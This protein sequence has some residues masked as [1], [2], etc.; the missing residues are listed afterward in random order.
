MLLVGSGCA[1][2]QSTR[3]DGA[4]AESA[5]GEKVEVGYGTQD[6]ERSTGA[7][8][9]VSGD[10][11]RQQRTTNDLSDLLQ[12]N[13]AGVTVTRTGGGIQV[14]IRGTNSIMGSNEPL[15]VV[16]GMPIEPGPNGMI[17]VVNPYDVESITVLKD[18]SAT[19]IYGARGGNGVIIIK[20]K[21]Q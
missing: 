4:A 1:S 7:I 15:Y 8:S 11:V 13:V 5:S 16:D 3:T 17:H 14:R 12:G 18:A 2:S 19:A 6:K 10:E 21:S 20:T 9:T